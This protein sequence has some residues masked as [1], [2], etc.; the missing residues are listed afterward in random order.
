MAKKT[1]TQEEVVST[2]T[3]PA[4]VT[5]LAANTS[6]SSASLV[7]LNPLKSLADRLPAKYQEDVLFLQRPS[8]TE[9]ASIIQQLPAEDQAKLMAIA[10]KT[11]SKKQGAHTQ[12][13]GFQPIDVRLNQGVGADP[14]RPKNSIPGDLYTADS[15]NL[16]TPF[17]AAVIHFYEGRIMWPARL[18]D[19]SS[20]AGEGSSRAPLCTSMDR[21]RGSRYGDCGTCPNASVPYNKGGCSKEVVAFMVD[22]E[23]TGIYVMRFTKSS[24][25]AGEAL[26]KVISKS[27]NIWDRWVAFSTEERKQSN[28][29][30]YFV[31]NAKPVVDAKKPE[32][33]NTPRTYSD[34]FSAFSRVIDADVYYPQL[35]DV[36]DR[37][38]RGG[39]EAV[40]GESFDANALLN[41]SGTDT[42]DNPDYATPEA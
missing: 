38:S 34:L 13:E 5:A 30:R 18:P 27:E 33:E 2:E 9:L 21:V 41:T 28:S 32:N 24:L 29:R 15:R 17:E 22:R 4:E 35:A 26:V 11:R 12:R 39:T 25:G 36:Y 10:A 19:G 23:M 40:V 3:K 6:T 31:L 37:S 14:A 16:P 20:A 42:G 7:Q 8:P 1:T